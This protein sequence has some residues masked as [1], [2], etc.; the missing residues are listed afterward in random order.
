MKKQT[1]ARHAATIALL[2]LAALSLLAACGESRESYRDE[3]ADVRCEKADECGNIGPG[4]TYETLDDCFVEERARMNDW[5]PADKCGGG[6]IDEAKFE[7]CL[8]RIDLAA[9]NSFWDQVSLLQNCNADAV[10]T[11]PE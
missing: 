10:C 4:Q 8:A 1:P 6:R 3:A 2:L 7:D 11:D 9:C 5:F